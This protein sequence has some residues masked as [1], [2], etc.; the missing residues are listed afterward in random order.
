MSEIS[1][2]ILELLSKKDMSYGELSKLTGIPKSALQRYA[3]GETEKIPIDRLE[4]IAKYL[5]VD[6]AYLMGWT[7]EAD[8][9]TDY[10]YYEIPRF[11]SVAAGFGMI[12]NS[13]PIGYDMLPFKTKYD[14]DDA[15]SIVV[16]GD[17]MYPKI[18]DGD[19]IVVKKQSSVDSGTV[20]VILIDETDAVVKK[21]TYGDD[22]IRL[23]SF[24]PEY[25]DRD[26]KGAD[27]QR[28]R[29]LGRVMKIVKEI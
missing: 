7:D 1:K 24:N 2:R 22:W 8:I 11:E 9:V 6:A 10:K 25:I 21:V 19:L 3:T 17:S 15:M 18:E 16:R 4:L 12:P 28:I 14:A 27:V 29:V 13:Q 20:A 23:H 5:N 26:F